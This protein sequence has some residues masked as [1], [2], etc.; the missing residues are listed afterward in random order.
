MNTKLSVSNTSVNVKKGVINSS[1]IKANIRTYTMI[2]VLV[3]IWI[4][5][6]IITGGM[7]L[8]ARNLA[9]LARQASVTSV[10][11]IGMVFVIVA[12]HIDLSVGSVLGLC[13]G[14]MAIL[15]S[16]MQWGVIP[17]L[18]AIIL[19]GTVI[20]AWHGYWV[21]YKKV[22]AFIVTLGG[23]LMF[24]GVLLGITKS[25]SISLSSPVLKAI[26]QDYLQKGAGIFLA[27][28]AV[29]ATIIMVFKARS[30]REKYNLDVPPVYQSILKVCLFSIL[31]IGFVLVMNNYEGIPIPVIIVLCLTLIF[32]F[33]ATKTKFGRCVYAIGGNPEAA[34]LSGIDNKRYTLLVFIISGFLSAIAGIILTGRLNAATSNAGAM[35]EMDAIAACVIGGTSMTGGIGSIPFALI[36][37]LVMASLDNGMSLLNTES[38]WQQIIKGLILILAVWVDMSTKKK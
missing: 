32:N 28:V 25:V 33:I 16:R 19:L 24:R 17:T 4:I 29:I 8:S 21:A 12:G 1:R 38:F 26:G 20:G 3:G 9:L 10:L 15:Q 23:Y 11:A 22:P 5:F 2:S 37:A 7:F 27:V 14:V 31:I 13:G 34:M 36:G 18:I 6:T 35:A 30:S